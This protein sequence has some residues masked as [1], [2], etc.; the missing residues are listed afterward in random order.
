MV[1]KIKPCQHD[2]L[3]CRL[4]E[5]E[6]CVFYITHEV[7]LC[8]VL[9][10]CTNIFSSGGGQSL[11]SMAGIPFLGRVPIDPQ[12]TVSGEK[13]QNSLRPPSDSPLFAVFQDIVKS[14]TKLRVGT[15]ETVVP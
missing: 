1:Q 13:G 9:Q 15:N 14:I 2:S 12:V 5:V 4:Y 7:L 3:F 11:A 6:L 10:E 8:F